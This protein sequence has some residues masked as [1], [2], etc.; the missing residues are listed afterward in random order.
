MGDESEGLGGIV[1]TQGRLGIGEG[2]EVGL[3]LMVAPF[4][5][6]KRVVKGSVLVLKGSQPLEKMCR[7]ALA[8][9][10]RSG[11]E[12]PSQIGARVSSSGRVVQRGFGQ[13][14]HGITGIDFPG[15][16]PLNRPGWMR[17]RCERM[18]SQREAI[19][20]EWCSVLGFK[21]RILR[22]RPGISDHRCGGLESV[23]DRVKS[24][25]GIDGFAVIVLRRGRHEASR[26][27]F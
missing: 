3:A 6:H 24:F 9:T 16:R 22:E 7:P 25:V 5:E 14:G 19:H 18:A 13:P 21:A 17:S 11:T 27:A 12:S 2:L 26:T 1:F 8:C 23:S 4:H 10:R 20:L 15:I